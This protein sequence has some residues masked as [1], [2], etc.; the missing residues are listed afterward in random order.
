MDEIKA[1]K[2]LIVSRQILLYFMDFFR[3]SL[4]IFDKANFYR[5][6]FEKYD[7]FRHRDKV[8]F[9]KEIYRL[10]RNGFVK[11]Y[12]DGKDEYLELMPRGQKQICKY[13]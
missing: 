11:K 8:K 5:V 13:F 3:L 12:F 6:P 10:K 4:P 1:R 9:S 7:K 2:T